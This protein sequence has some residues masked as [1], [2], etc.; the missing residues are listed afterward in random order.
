MTDSDYNIDEYPTLDDGSDAN[1]TVFDS[2]GNAVDGS[3]EGEFDD[4]TTTE[5]DD[6]GTLPQ[7]DEEIEPPIEY[8][9]DFKTGQLTGGKVKGLEALKIW[10]WNALQ[11]E[12]FSFEQFTWN[13]GSELSS[14]IGKAQPKSM[15]ESDARRMVEDCVTQNKY[16]TGIDR[17]KCEVNGESLKI[18]FRLLT[19]FGEVDMGVTV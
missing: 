10:A 1:A 15:T 2:D 7:I 14:L 12:R 3:T 18:A 4:Y 11:I 9:I 16:I 17:F 5:E 6:P 19:T 8:G 13:C